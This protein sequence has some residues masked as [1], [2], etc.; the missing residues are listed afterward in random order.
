MSLAS[1]LPAGLDPSLKRGLDLILAGFAGALLTPIA[2]L[3]AA[4]I[5]LES[6]GPILFQCQRL[7]RWGRPIRLW[8]FR[9]ML[10]G[11]PER[12]NADGSRLV[13]SRD[14]R[15]TRVG[16]FLRRGLDELPQV[17]S[18]L[19]GQLSFIGPRPDDLF[20][21]DLYDGAEWLKLSVI[22]GI[23]G[24]AQVS[25]RNDIPYHE[26]LK[27]DVYY[28]LRRDIVLDVRILIRTLALAMGRPPARPLVDIAAIEAVAAMPELAGRGAAIAAAVRAKARF[29]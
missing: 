14:P 27:Y 1:K 20:A 23:T 13:E 9:T 4:A 26:R 15:V 17:V 22:P 7:G 29:R 18:V 6:P 25:G 21:V 10:H 12:F 19:R 16:A 3:I 2:P 8:K 11:A 5:R 24:L 28:A